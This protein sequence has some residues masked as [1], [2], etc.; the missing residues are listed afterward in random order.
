MVPYTPYNILELKCVNGYAA[1]GIF[2][3]FLRDEMKVHVS[4]HR[5]F[6][7]GYVQEWRREHD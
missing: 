5:Q 4:V 7:L 1:G 3:D 6:I 2:D